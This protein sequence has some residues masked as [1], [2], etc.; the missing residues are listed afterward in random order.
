[1]TGYKAVRAS[2]AV[3]PDEIEAIKAWAAVG[4]SASQIGQLLGRSHSTVYWVADQIG[5]QFPGTVERKRIRRQRIKQRAENGHGSMPTHYNP[6]TGHA[7]IAP[8]AAMPAAK[9]RALYAGRRYRD[10][11]RA[12][13]PE[14]QWRP[15]TPVWQI[16]GGMSSSGWA[17]M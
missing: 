1:M 2:Q 15:S 11:L 8:Q 6:G 5:L 10:D 9:V 13:T 12:A 16:D 4:M 14:P 3:R 7:A 17:V